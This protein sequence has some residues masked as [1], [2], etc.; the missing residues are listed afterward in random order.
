MAIVLQI[1]LT[2][3]FYEQH[4][5][6]IEESIFIGYMTEDEKETIELSEGVLHKRYKTTEEKTLTDKRKM[7]KQK[8]RRALSRSFAVFSL[9]RVEASKSYL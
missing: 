7:I 6:E 4:R 2:V 8:V 1:Y 3:E 9:S 5:D